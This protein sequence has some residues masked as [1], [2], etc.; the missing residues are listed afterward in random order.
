MLASHHLMDHIGGKCVRILLDVV[1]DIFTDSPLLLWMDKIGAIT[2]HNET[3]GR[4][5]TAHIRL[6]QIILG[7]IQRH[8]FFHHDLIIGGHHLLMEPVEREVG[9]EN[10]HRATLP[11]VDGIEVGDQGRDRIIVL[12]ERLRPHPLV[13]LQC[14]LKPLE[15]EI[16]V[17]GTAYIACLDVRT[18]A[19]DGIGAEPPSL[20][21][22]VTIH[23]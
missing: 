1:E 18:V 19:P 15:F 22:I 9:T 13:R 3:I 4:L 17:V 14:L 23:E 10:G 11:V 20:L 2:C 16:V 6:V 5:E 8:P 12:E 7:R 21:R